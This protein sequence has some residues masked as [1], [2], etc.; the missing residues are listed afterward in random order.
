MPWPATAAPYAAALPLPVAARTVHVLHPLGD[1]ARLEALIVPAE[2]SPAA[3]VCRGTLCSAPVQ[4][5]DDL[6]GGVVEIGGAA[7]RV[8]GVIVHVSASSDAAD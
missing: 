6:L 2:P 3:Y 1:A 4:E 5:A 7:G 8:R